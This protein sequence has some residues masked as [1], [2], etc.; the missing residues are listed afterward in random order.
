MRNL[1]HVM[2]TFS[3]LPTNEDFR[4]LTDDQLDFIILSMQEDNREQ[5]R[6]RKGLT[7]EN[8]YYDTSFDEEVWSKAEGE[9]DV[10]KDGHDPNDIAR[11]VEALT[12]EEDVRNL[13]MKFDSLEEYNAFREAGGKTT[14]ESEIDQYIN[15]QVALAEEKAKRLSAT[16]G[17]KLVNDSDLPE[18]S[19]NNSLGTTMTDL[20]KEAIDKSIALFNSNDDDDWTVL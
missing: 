13:A 1:W 15:R 16:K 7:A 17:K 3:V 14:R 19:N 5:E 4:T 6:A 10:L 11:Q 18:V 9:W 12:R 2:K 20:D 8:E